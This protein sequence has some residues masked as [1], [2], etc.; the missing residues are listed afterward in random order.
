MNW[1]KKGWIPKVNLLFD[2]ISY[3]ERSADSDA[4]ADVAFIVVHS[5]D[6]A[7]IGTVLA[8]AI[9]P[10]AASVQ[11]NELVEKKMDCENQLTFRSRNGDL[12][13]R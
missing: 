12:V 4:G 5:T 10:V 7:G 3:A 8:P 1:S 9:A 11:V 6:G 13:C 2:P